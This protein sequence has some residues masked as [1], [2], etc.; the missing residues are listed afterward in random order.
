MDGAKHNWL[1]PPALRRHDSNVQDWEEWEDVMV[2]TPI[3]PENSTTAAPTPSPPSGTRERTPT[4]STTSRH[5]TAKVK[6]LRSR[7]RQKAQNA[8]AGIKLI[9]DILSTQQL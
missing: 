9:T 4:K 3:E 5:S 7:R 6:R 8:K 2:V 1:K